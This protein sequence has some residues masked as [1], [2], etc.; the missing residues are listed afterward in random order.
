[1]QFESEAHC[2][3]VDLEYEHSMQKQSERENR[4]ASESY[5]DAELAGSCFLSVLP[6]RM[7][8][9]MDESLTC[10]DLDYEHEMQQNAAQTLQLD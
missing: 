7:M 3:G 10:I 1:M 4:N 8:R 5:Y 6:L 2:D 9:D